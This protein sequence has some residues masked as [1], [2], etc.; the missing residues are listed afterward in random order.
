M[1]A[2]SSGRQRL[3]PKVLAAA[4]AAVAVVAT[5]AVTGTGFARENARSAT[6]GGY[7]YV[8]T[9][10]QT[11]AARAAAL[12]AAGSTA[13]APTGKTIGVIQLSGTSAQSIGV[14][15]T[16]RQIAKMFGYKVIVCDP[17][18]DPQK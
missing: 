10:A 9:P 7:T 8:G 4:V 2:V 1:K 18:F 13:E 16:A 5:G 3:S 15:A 12:K 6:I 11:A 17:N 14:L